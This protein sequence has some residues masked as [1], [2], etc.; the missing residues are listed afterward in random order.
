MS[1]QNVLF[2]NKRKLRGSSPGIHA[3]KDHSDLYY[4]QQE[5]L[6]FRRENTIAISLRTKTDFTWDSRGELDA[7]G[8]L[9]DSW[10]ILFVIVP[11]GPSLLR[12]YS[13][14]YI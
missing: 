11:P 2:S 5:R 14:H 12:Q 10:E 6:R 3:K 8:K 9:C 13:T 4:G 1:E 7:L